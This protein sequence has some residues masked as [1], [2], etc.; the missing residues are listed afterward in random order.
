MELIITCPPGAL[1]V[2]EE[3]E[4]EESS[5]NDDDDGGTCPSEKRATRKCTLTFP[6]HHSS[7][8]YT[9]QLVYHEK[10]DM[11]KSRHRHKS[12]ESK[13]KFADPSGNMSRGHKS[14]PIFQQKIPERFASNIETDGDSSQKPSF[15]CGFEDDDFTGLEDESPAIST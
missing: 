6:G 14:M 11:K 13:I 5:S 1:P 15:G 3:E 10:G 2:E 9:S 8:L 12:D 4:E 7:V